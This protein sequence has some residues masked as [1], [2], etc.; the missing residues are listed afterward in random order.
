MRA[1]LTGLA[2]LAALTAAPAY[3]S[4]FALGYQKEG[5]FNVDLDISTNPGNPITKELGFNH[6][7]FSVPDITTYYLEEPGLIFGVISGM[8]DTEA[9]RVA[10]KQQAEK[11]GS[12]TYSWA[13][14]QPAPIPTGRWNRWSYSTGTGNGATVI[15][16]NGTAVYDPAIVVEYKRYNMDIVTGPVLWGEQGV[17]WMPSGEISGRSIIM[18]K[19]TK[20]RAT[21]F[22]TLAVPFNLHL[23]YKPKFFPWFNVEGRAGWDFVSWG[24]FALA[25]YDAKDGLKNYTQGWAYGAKAS[26]GVD[27]F[28]VY[29]DFSH[30]I[31]PLWNHDGYARRYE[32][33]TSVI[34]A[35]LDLGNLIGRLFF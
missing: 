5:W 19:G 26:L 29:Y 6:L 30:R 20:G 8:A 4:Q 1:T 14:G 27:W 35:R 24:L 32:S 22:S 11:D 23:G 16:P 21:D 33:D 12:L 34:G 2:L 28:Q 25:S 7:Q 18:Y 3:A 9:N 10:A 31:E 17:Y 15:L 13:Y